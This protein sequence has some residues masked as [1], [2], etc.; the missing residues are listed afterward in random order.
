M[1]LGNATANLSG[2]SPGIYLGSQPWA[3]QA[4]SH[5]W[6]LMCPR[7]RQSGT[8]SRSNRRHSMAKTWIVDGLKHDRS[9][10]H[11]NGRHQ[12]QQLRVNRYVV[13][14]T[15][16]GQARLRCILETF[17]WSGSCMGCWLT[18]RAIIESKR[19]PLG[20]RPRGRPL[21]SVLSVRHFPL[22]SDVSIWHGAAGTGPKHVSPR[23]WLHQDIF[24]RISRRVHRFMVQAV[25]GTWGLSSPSR[26]S[27]GNISRGRRR[28]LVPLGLGY[29]GPSPGPVG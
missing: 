9:Q 8:N 16:T 28:A 21:D 11:G 6:Q 25:W 2:T 24:A 15:Q 3:L 10:C 20:L 17:R 19:R 4:L 5:P 18:S 12:M 13:H 22:G 29:P 27:L 7:S 14:D 1:M 23:T 26:S